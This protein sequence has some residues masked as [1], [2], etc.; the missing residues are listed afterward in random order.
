MQTFKFQGK[1]LRAIKTK[2]IQS[3]S[4][5]KLKKKTIQKNTINNK[6]ND[7]KL[8]ILLQHRSRTLA[9][10]KPSNNLQPKQLWVLRVTIVNRNTREVTHH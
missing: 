8:R 2:V 9:R 10:Y 5:Y 7:F 4:P 3:Y 6:K 1:Q